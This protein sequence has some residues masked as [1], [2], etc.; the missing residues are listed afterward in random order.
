MVAGFVCSRVEHKYNVNCGVGILVVSQP[1]KLIKRVRFPHSAPIS[2]ES[3]MNKV[4]KLIEVWKSGLVDFDVDPDVA[5]NNSSM[6]RLIME[7]DDLN[8]NIRFLIG[9]LKNNQPREQ[10]VN[11][12]NTC[13]SKRNELNELINRKWV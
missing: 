4:E 11:L 8:G 12:I 9:H 3:F 7:I 5:F 1:S 2:R 6:M 13:L 10:H